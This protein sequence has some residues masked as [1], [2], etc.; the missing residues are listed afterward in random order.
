LLDDFIVIFPKLIS[1]NQQSYRNS[2]FNRFIIKQLTLA[3]SFIM[4]PQL[5]FLSLQPTIV[6]RSLH[7]LAI[8]EL[9]I[10][11]VVSSLASSF[12]LAQFLLRL[13]IDE[14]LQQAAPLRSLF[15]LVVLLTPVLFMVQDFKVRLALF[16][17]VQ[18]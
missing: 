12:F 16:V 4:I 15:K 5:K 17:V 9:E 3:D 7:K 11:F 13:S 2:K 8:T 10:G 14:S 1:T 6:L 18:P